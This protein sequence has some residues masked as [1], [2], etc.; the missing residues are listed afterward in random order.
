MFI[1]LILF[2]HLNPIYFVQSG[3][4]AVIKRF[5]VVHSKVIDEGMHIKTPLIDEVIH[6]NVRP[7]TAEGSAIT[8][9]K[10]N[11]PIEVTYKVLYNVS[12]I[13]DTIVLYKNNPM[14]NFAVSKITD[15]IKVVG[16]RYTAS[17]FVTR[18][19]T[20]RMELV[21]LSK[22]AVINPQN[23]KAAIN[24]IDIPITNV[25]F[26]DDYERAIKEKQVMQ[27]KAQKKE[28]EYQAAQRDAQITITQAKAEAEALTIKSQAISKSPAILKLEEIK[29]WNGIVPLDA[30]T[31]IIGD[32]STYKQFSN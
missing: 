19:D 23:N 31:V 24:V 7:Q 13:S 3:E 6:V 2:L 27:Q 20:V 4:K 28:Y 15:A 12:D 18:R 26:D 29:K 9:T 25:D 17:D 21:E 10:D 14:D 30:K 1:G 32:H 8:Y 22:Q 11:Q 5:G 16:G